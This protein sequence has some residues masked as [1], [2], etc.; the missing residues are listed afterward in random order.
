M[1]VSLYR[2][3]QSMQMGLGL[4]FAASALEGRPEVLRSYVLARLDAA[5]AAQPVAEAEAAEAP[6]AAE[7][8]L[9]LAA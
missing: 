6:I 2:F 4:S 7:R 5:P 9:Q 8:E 3:F 1:F